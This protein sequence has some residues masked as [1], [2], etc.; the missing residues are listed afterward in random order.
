[1][2]YITRNYGFTLI[3][4]LVVITIMLVIMGGAIA[5]FMT[6]RDRRAAEESA[7][8][9]QA[10]FVTAQQKAAVQESPSNCISPAPPAPQVAP[11][12]GYQVNYDSGTRTFSLNALCAF[13]PGGNTTGIPSTFTAY[14]LT[15]NATITNSIKSIV[16]PSTVTVISGQNQFN[17]YTLQRGT[18]TTVTRTFTFRI[19]SDDYFFTVTP[20]GT[21]SNVQN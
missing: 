16:V 17:F 4:L 15:D 18:N 21:I 8:R 14:P 1:M 7:K 11:L 13:P 20:T 3:E 10:L 6:F 5:G 2:K 12:Q 19:G 9:V